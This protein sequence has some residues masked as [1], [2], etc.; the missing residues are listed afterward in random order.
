MSSYPLVVVRLPKIA[1]SMRSQHSGPIE[2]CC[3]SPVCHIWLCPACV[4]YLPVR[5][6]FVK[7]GAVDIPIVIG[8]FLGT[9]LMFARWVTLQ[10]CL[11]RCWTQNLGFLV[12]VEYGYYFCVPA[13]CP[14]VWSYVSY[15]P[16]TGV[17][18]GNVTPSCVGAGWVWIVIDHEIWEHWFESSNLWASVVYIRLVEFI[19]TYV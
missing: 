10:Y 3:S 4:H 6:E 15:K 9:P 19:M 7:L 2:I 12:H 11:V 16:K 13:W 5:Y 18:L 14:T 17:R 8:S 1:G